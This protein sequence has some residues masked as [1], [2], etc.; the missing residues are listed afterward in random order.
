MNNILRTSIFSF[1][2]TEAERRALEV[3]AEREALKPSEY[4]RG[5]LRRKIETLGVPAGMVSLMLTKESGTES[6]SK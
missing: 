2:L 6:A 5:L 3:L 4:M 1:R